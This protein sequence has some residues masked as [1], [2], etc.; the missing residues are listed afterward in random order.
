MKTRMNI[1]FFVVMLANAL[2]FSAFDGSAPVVDAVNINLAQ[3]S[4]GKCG[5]FMSDPA[6]HILPG[7]RAKS[8]QRGCTYAIKD[9]NGNFV[10]TLYWDGK[11]V[12][13]G[14]NQL[15]QVGRKIHILE[16]GDSAFRV[17]TY[18][19]S[20]PLRNEYG[21][22]VGFLRMGM[23]PTVRIL[24]NAQLPQDQGIKIQ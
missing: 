13:L 6:Y 11:I 5:S 17:L 2:L 21:R 24:S 16:P 19:R 3:D 20:V 22:I 8:L 9:G 7:E 23:N 10:E 1:L 15:K 14:G 18:G 12:H 4:L